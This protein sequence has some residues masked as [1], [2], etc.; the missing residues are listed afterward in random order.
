[1][2][3]ADTP[4]SDSRTQS[5]PRED[6][7]GA[8]RRSIGSGRARR[9]RRLV[10]GPTSAALI[11][12]I[13]ACGG[14]LDY[15]ETEK[16]DVVEMLHGVEVEDPYR[17]L[18]DDNDPEVLAW[19]DA[20]NEVTFD[21]LRSLPG[22]D[23]LEARLTE[24]Q[25]YARRSAP[26]RFGPH[27]FVRANDGLQDQDVLYRTPGP[28]TPEDEWE[29]LLDPNRLSDDGTVSLGVTSFTK[30]GA[31]MA[32]A[33]GEAGSD[34][35]EFH[36]VE[37]ASG[38]QRDDHLRWIKFSGAAWTHDNGGFFYSRYPEPDPDAAQGGLNR[39]QTIWYHRL[40]TP[41]DSDTLV[42][43]RPE[44]PDLLFGAE[45]SDDGRFLVVSI[46]EGTSQ[47]NRIHILDL[48]DPGAPRLDGDAAPLLDAGDASWVFLGNDGARFYFL[49]DHDAPR[50]RV[51]AVNVTR[52]APANW[53]GVVPETEQTLETARIVGDRLILGYLDD[54]KSRLAVHTLGG[55]FERDVPLPGIGSAGQLTGGREDE[56]LHFS[57]SSFLI[58]PSVFRYELASGET[59]PHW[60][61]DFDFDFDGYETNQVFFASADG[62]EVPMFLTHRKDLRRDGDN[63]VMLYGYGG[64][65]ISLRPGFSPWNLAF[66]ERGGVYAQV[67]LRGGGEYGEAW[68]EAG[69]RE[70]KQNVF[71]D[72][73]SAAEFLIHD[74]VTR[75]SR[76]AIAGGSNGGLLVGAVLNQRPELFGA[77]LPAVGVMDML[78]FHEF[79]IGWAWASDYGSPDDPEMFPVL[80]AYS[81]Y[82]NI[83]P[84]EDFPPTLVTTADHDDRVAPGHSFKY[85]ARLQEVHGGGEAPVL[86]RVQKSAGHGGGMPVSMQ[87]ALEADRWA[88]VLHHL[89]VE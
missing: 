6:L 84:A 37:V 72:F 40:G 11:A 66:L 74:S 36:V 3:M 69:M 64:F 22:R 2:A 50:Y 28:G 5:P 41:Q 71:D 83:A 19:V 77:A 47:E 32:Y 76:L 43:A 35:Q 7:A 45:V 75:P 52:P 65:N 82:H 42:F 23:A 57:F 51:V 17:W 80:R 26:F 73:V 55:S 29:V 9:F 87:V 38:E 67:N 62:T 12:A 18:E 15:P 20:Q 14:G 60:T 49:T 63:P 53:L 79:T 78:R 13:V 1:M 24:L 33:L 44:E 27:W 16:E 59:R 61:P 4:L 34:W 88:F 54:A 46:H 85:A 58:P 56:A 86:L 48:G 68:H 25:D 31:L 21:Y 10:V 81:P 89:G 8:R 30:D 39:N 70:N